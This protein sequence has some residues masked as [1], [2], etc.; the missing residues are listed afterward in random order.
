MGLRIQFWTPIVEEG[1]RLQSVIVDEPNENP[2]RTCQFSK[3]HV[4]AGGG[5]VKPDGTSEDLC[6]FH[7]VC[8]LM[9]HTRTCTEMSPGEREHVTLMAIASL[10]WEIKNGWYDHM[11]A[12]PEA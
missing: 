8:V 6:T 9:F 7:F 1:A 5:I 3:C 12:P 2:T 10:L 11:M 4:G